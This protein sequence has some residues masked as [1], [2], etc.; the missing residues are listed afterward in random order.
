MATALVT[1]SS[2]FIGHHLVKELSSRGWEVKTLDL[3]DD[4]TKKEDWIKYLEGVEYVFHLAG[5]LDQYYHKGEADF[6]KCVDVNVKSV[7]VLFEAIVENK[8]PIKKVTA[9]SSQSVYGEGLYQAPSGLP[10]EETEFDPLRPISA[11]GASKAAMEDILMTLGRIY[12]IPVTAL[13]YS[14]VLGPGQ[15]Y[16]DPDSRILPCF[17]DMAQKGEIITHEDGLQL[18]D[19]VHVQDVV[20]ATIFCA[21]NTA[22]DYKILNVGSGVN[23]SVIEVAEY[24]GKRFG[25]PAR[26]GGKKR[27]NTARNQIMSIEKIGTLGWKPKHSWQEAVDQFT[28][29]SLKSPS[30]ER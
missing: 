19:F 14:I 24:I 30:S 29:E 25:V 7:A 11:Y 12:S 5:H 9:A 28:E 8:L 15:S 21:F 4:V 18:R 1:G 2:G 20:D 13:R 17:F 27:I 22:S 6:S 16:K 10:L 26:A 3:P 23:T